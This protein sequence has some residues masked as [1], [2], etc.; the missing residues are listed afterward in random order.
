MNRN[1]II[2][3]NKRTL[4]H[5]DL[6]TCSICGRKMERRFSHD[7][8]PIRVES[9][10]DEDENRCC[11]ECNSMI[12]IPVR[13]GLG[14]DGGGF[15]ELMKTMTHKQLLRTL[16]GKSNQKNWHS[17]YVRIGDGLNEWDA[18][19]DLG[20]HVSDVELNDALNN[21]EIAEFYS[22][23]MARDYLGYWN[24]KDYCA[25]LLA[26]MLHNLRESDAYDKYTKEIDAALIAV[27]NEEK[28]PISE[29]IFAE[30]LLDYTTVYYGGEEEDEYDPSE[31]PFDL[32]VYWDGGLVA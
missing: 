25:D 30:M 31:C 22:K 24:S 5:T 29:D 10:Y 14:R 23:K 20:L 2:N 3:K 21:G 32:A 18:Y 26:N 19:E 7:A 11:E 1:K 28:D 16:N 4:K 17:L 8:Y 9:W 12:V 6:L 13:I 15:H 27:A